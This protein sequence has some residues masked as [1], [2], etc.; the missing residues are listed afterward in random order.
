ML[1]YL[2]V[3]LKRLL[4]RIIEPTRKS[5]KKEIDNTIY[6]DSKLTKP[7][8]IKL[9]FVLVILLVV[10]GVFFIWRW[11]DKRGDKLV[12][13]PG[14]ESTEMTGCGEIIVEG[15]KKNGLSPF[16][17]VLKAKITGNFNKD[18]EVCNW[19]VNGKNH[20][21]SQPYNEYCILYGLTLYNVGD[22]RIGYKV[23]GLINCPKEVTL[24]VTGLT[25]KE[26][27]RQ[28]EIK[29]SGVRPEDL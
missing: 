11:W 13:S 22:Y 15:N 19:T 29:V 5:S 10:V 1:N 7:I 16:S 6:R 8:F 2:S 23:N 14:L 20:V 25:E 4:R 9:A 17:P 21:N 12:Q 27:A 28:L 3:V 18:K 26:K 24:K